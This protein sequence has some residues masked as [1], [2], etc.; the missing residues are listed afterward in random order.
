MRQNIVKTVGQFHKPKLCFF[1][2]SQQNTQASFNQEIE[3]ESANV[4]NKKMTR[5]K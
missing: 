3:G 4:Q 2:K 1:E 5:D